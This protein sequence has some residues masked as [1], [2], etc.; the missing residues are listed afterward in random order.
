MTNAQSKMMNEYDKNYCPPTPRN[1]YLAHSE[2]FYSACKKMVEISNYY[3][4][5]AEVLV[6]PLPEDCDNLVMFNFMGKNGKP[7]QSY[8]WDETKS[9]IEKPAFHDWTKIMN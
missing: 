1:I 7:V 8:V 9:T 4:D 6:K 5:G 3:Y 2:K